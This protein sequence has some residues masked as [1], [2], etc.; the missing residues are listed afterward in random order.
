[1]D[2]LVSFPFGESV[3]RELR[4]LGIDARVEPPPESVS[5]RWRLVKGFW[6]EGDDRSYR[7]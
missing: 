1:M 2:A 7:T 4:R 5:K 3:A 6:S